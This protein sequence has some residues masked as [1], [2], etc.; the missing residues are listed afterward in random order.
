MPTSWPAGARHRSDDP[1]D[2]ALDS[3]SCEE[4][5]ATAAYLPYRRLDRATIAAV[6]GTG[7]GKGTRTVAVLRRGHHHDG[8]RG[9]P[10]RRCGPRRRPS[11]DAVVLDRRPAY[12]DKTNA[13]AVHAAL[14]LAAD[15]P[16]RRLRRRGALRRRRAARR[17]RQRRGP[18]LVVAADIRTGLPGGP[19]RPPAATRAAALLVGDDERRPV[20]AELLGDG[21]RDRG[22]PRP[23]A[24]ARR[25]PL[26]ACGRSGSAR[27]ATC[28]SA[29]RPAEA[30]LKAGRPRRADQ[31]D[32]ARRHRHPRPRRPAPSPKTLGVAADARGRRPRRRRRQHRRRPAR[33]AA[34]AARSSRPRPGQVIALRRA[35]RRRRRAACSAPPTRSPSYTP[36]APARRPGRGRRAVAY[37]KYLAWRGMLPVEPPRRPEPA[38][39][40]ASAA[41]RV[42][43]WKFGFVGSDGA[44]GAVHLPPSAERRSSARADGRRAGHD[45]HVHR[46]PARLLAEPAGRVRGRRLRRRRPAADRADRRRPTRSRS[47]AGS[48]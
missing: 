9:G 7:G 11:A 17:A 37:G 43:D 25:R 46:R 38:R 28:R 48:R 34:V 6:A 26:E 47:A 29:T 15:V 30:A 20:L 33:A 35:R 3:P 40:S 23:L 4:S 16:A 8:R 32:H 41:G 5:S 13:T 42:D 1:S 44:D 22:V 14:R 39:P 2:P 36:A 27:P 24:H 21:R 31:V 18:A 10:A 45:R 19:T 12:L